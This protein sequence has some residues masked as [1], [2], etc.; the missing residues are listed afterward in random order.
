M[1]LLLAN[2][3]PTLFIHSQPLKSKS[4]FLAFSKKTKFSDNDKNELWIEA[5]H[6][7]S[8]QAFI[9]SALKHYRHEYF[10]K[11]NNDQD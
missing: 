8:N 1:A 4:Y 10:N 5:Q 3:N 7:R 11:L 9:S 6:V 2:H